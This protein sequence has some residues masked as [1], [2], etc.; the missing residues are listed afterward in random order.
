MNDKAGKRQDVDWYDWN[1]ESETL[2]Q[3][4]AERR[5][6]CPRLPSAELEALWQLLMTVWDGYVISKYARDIL[7]QMGLAERL[8]GWQFITRQ[9][10]AV[11]DTYG[12][13]KDERYGIRGPAG[14]K[15]WVLP[16]SEFRRLRGEGFLLP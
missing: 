14:D 12:L 1:P 3:R 7:V 10:M 13:L 4:Q 2:E 8:N 6:L 15:L 5:R 9:G 16:S 11:L